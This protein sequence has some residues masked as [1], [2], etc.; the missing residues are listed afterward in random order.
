MS[1]S[2]EALASEMAQHP[3]VEADTLGR[4]NR[5]SCGQRPAEEMAGE[6]QPTGI[7]GRANLT[8]SRSPCRVTSLSHGFSFIWERTREEKTEVKKSHLSCTWL[9][10]KA[11]DQSR[12][13]CHINANGL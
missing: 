4:E 1:Q 2:S 6:K 3:G 12:N 9:L 13:P 10:T 8:C 7:A 11:S 5:G